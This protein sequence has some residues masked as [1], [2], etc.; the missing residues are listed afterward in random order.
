MQQ[1]G[2][3]PNYK[4]STITPIFRNW[5]LSRF[6]VRDGTSEWR[7]LF[8]VLYGINENRPRDGGLVI[9]APLLA[10]M[11]AQQWSPH[12]SGEKFL[13]K[14]HSR[15]PEL[16]LTWSKWSSSGTA[17]TLSFILPED[18]HTALES[19]LATLPP[20]SQRVYFLDG[21]KIN[22]HRRSQARTEEKNHVQNIHEA[23]QER[24]TADAALM[25]KYLLNLQPHHFAKLLHNLE[26]TK[27]AIMALPEDKRV[28]E[29]NILEAIVNQ[30][31]QFYG[32]CENSPR[33]AI[34]GQ[35]IGSLKSTIRK[36]LT[37]DWIELD[38]QSA[39]LA[40]NA[41]LWGLPKTQA[42]LSSGGH[43]WNELFKW[44]DIHPDPEIKEQ[45]KTAT[46]A[47]TFGSSKKT[48]VEIL[49]N[50]MAKKF[51]KHP[52]VQELL[53]GRQQRL[54]EIKEANGALDA[55]GRWR[56]LQ[57]GS[58]TTRSVLAQ[59]AQSYEQVLI[60]EVFKLAETTEEFTILLYQSDGISVVFR[61][62]N[63]KVLWLHRIR[64]HVRL[65]TESFGI[66][67]GI[68]W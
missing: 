60:A 14:M 55:Y 23:R 26:D 6:K 8:Y 22:R 21:Q 31:Q 3:R 16:K 52:F 42:F 41:C 36:V 30:P 61:D 48:V 39:Q 59:I 5:L 51:L 43:W 28:R 12:Y 37:R 49:G 53:T 9:P 47:L 45:F 35:G 68:A 7:F 40:I 34:L 66:A 44:F 20:E 50:S 62:Q 17:R 67:T 11:E 15:F 13:I 57:G 56:A 24:A 32:F 33:L 4:R 38:L 29:L 63:R 18:V 10:K 2:Y 27:Q 1:S 46:Y 58:V 65:K 19:E 25:Y 64:E 54:V